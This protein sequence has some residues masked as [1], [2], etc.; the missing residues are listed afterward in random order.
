MAGADDVIK[1]TMSELEKIF[2]DHKGRNTTRYPHQLRIYDELFCGYRNTP[3]CVLE[4]GVLNGGGLQIWKEYFG[5]EAKIYGID[6][7]PGCE[8]AQEGQIKVFT[9]QQED[10]VFI[11]SV[12][13][14][15][16]PVDILIDDASHISRHQI[17]MFEEVFLRMNSKAIYAV[18]DTHTSYRD[19]HEGGLKKDGTFVEYCKNLSDIINARSMPEGMMPVIAYTDCI[20]G[21]YFYQSLIIIEK[22][23]EPR[24]GP[25][26]VGDI[27]I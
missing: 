16:P 13:D 25:I 8:K 15:I 5:K 14:S 11:K 1:E 27:R 17:A 10:R 21:V 23:D 7:C 26:S 19:T 2:F 18:E 20:W 3:V 24:Y 22:S 4:V 9:G 12:L 6:S